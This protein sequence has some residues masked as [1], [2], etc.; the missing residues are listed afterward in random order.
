[1]ELLLIKYSAYILYFPVQVV[2][3]ELVTLI[4]IIYCF[5]VFRLMY[6]YCL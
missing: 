6:I 4:S 5:A 1:M 2:S 3:V